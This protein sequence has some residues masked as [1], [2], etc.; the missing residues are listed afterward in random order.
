[1]VHTPDFIDLSAKVAYTFGMGGR[2]KLQLNAG[3]QNILDAFQK[4]LDKGTYRDSGYF[5]G[6]TQPRTVYI[7]AK[8]FM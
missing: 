7:G 5:Y 4:D 8:V 6:P 3:V 1:M 2:I